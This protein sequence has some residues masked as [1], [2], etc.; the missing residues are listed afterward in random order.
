MIIMTLV[1]ITL[2]PIEEENRRIMDVDWAVKRYLENW[3]FNL[4]GKIYDTIIALRII[5]SYSYD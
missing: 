5:A 1:S 4:T 2:Y 3:I